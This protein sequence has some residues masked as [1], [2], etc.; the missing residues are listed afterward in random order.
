MN[1]SKVEKLHGN[2]ACWLW[3][4]VTV[5]GYPQAGRYE[6]RYQPVRKVYEQFVGQII[7]RAPVRQRCGNRACVR[8]DHL[9]IGIDEAMSRKRTA[10]RF[11]RYVETAGPDECWPW[12]GLKSHN[13]YGRL[14]NG[15]RLIP[16]THYAWEQSCG[17]VPLGMCVLHRCDNPPCCNPAHLWLG[18]QAENVADRDEKGRTCNGDRHWS[19]QFP[20]RQPRGE[21]RVGAKLTDDKVRRIRELSRN[22]WTQ[23]RIAKSIGLSQA[24][25]SRV[26]RGHTWA[27]VT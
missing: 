21:A 25:V 3:R 26:L 2:D 10:E 16:A 20:E 23:Q 1:W 14:W 18:T 15:E 13:G 9:I 11:A 17:P 4:G 22:G 6:H 7:G 27:H 5:N 12:R 19:R 24:G 8:P